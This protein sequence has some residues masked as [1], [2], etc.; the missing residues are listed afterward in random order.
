MGMPVKTLLNPPMGAHLVHVA[1][2]C[3]P[4]AAPTVLLNKMSEIGGMFVLLT[5]IPVQVSSLAMA[6]GQPNVMLYPLF[7]FAIHQKT[8]EDFTGRAYLPTDMHQLDDVLGY[9]KKKSSL[10]N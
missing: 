1:I 2:L 6:N 4:D 3:P 10:I 8:W 5:Q 9:G 7:I